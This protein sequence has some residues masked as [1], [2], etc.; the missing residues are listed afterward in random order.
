[1]NSAKN[2]IILIGDSTKYLYKFVRWEINLALSKDLPIIAVNLN[3]LQKMDN[4]RCPAILKNELAI[5]VSFNRNIIK[6]SL[7]NWPLSHQEYKRNNKSGIITTYQ[8]FTT[9][10]N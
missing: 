4:E 9:T 7:D 10:C 1:M 6:H 5:H 3:N 2:F 8:K